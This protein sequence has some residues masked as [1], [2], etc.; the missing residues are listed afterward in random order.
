MT[1]TTAPPALLPATPLPLPAS[2]G[3]R[4]RSPLRVGLGVCAVFFGLFGAWAALAPLAQGVTAP[5]SVS[6]DGSRRVVQHLE[7]GII[8]ALHVREGQRV[9]AGQSLLELAATRAEAEHSILR[10]RL[11]AH[12]AERARLIAE[13]QGAEEITFPARLLDAVRQDPADSPVAQ[14]LMAA[15]TL[16][17]TSRRDALATQRDILEQRLRQLSRQIE[18]YQAQIASA[19]RQ[20]LLI[21]EEVG[22]VE[23]LVRQGL[24]RKPRLLALQRAQA[25]LD[26]VRGQAMAAIAEAEE[27]VGQTRLEMVRLEVDRLEEINGALADLEEKLAETERSVE[28]ARDVLERVVIRAPVGGSVLNLRTTTIGGVIGPGEPILDLVPDE[29]RLII[30]ARVS[31]LDIDAMHPGLPAT[32]VLTA[33]P[34]RTTPTVSGRVAWVSADRQTEEGAPGKEGD[35]YYM[36]RVEVDAPAMAALPQGV[37]LVP[38]M[39]VGVMI[40]TD[41]RTLLDYLLDPLIDAAREGLSE[42]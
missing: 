28:A 22:A 10:G 19:D 37:T 13:R 3:A 12:L 27:A 23:G 15:Q 40:K 5:G 9:A 6:P 4:L 17:F 18:G 20:N 33:Y 41:E 7:G 42:E 16:M 1:T 34:R 2:L 21:Q 11:L 30:D 35:S 36:A 24:E 25:E 26:G 29:E 8:A 38:G 31:P 39:P 14:Q 32:V